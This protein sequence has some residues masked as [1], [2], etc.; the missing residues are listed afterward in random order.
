MRFSR[1]NRVSCPCRL[2]PAIRE[3]V[4]GGQPSRPIR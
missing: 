4:A 2:V 1:A 3:A